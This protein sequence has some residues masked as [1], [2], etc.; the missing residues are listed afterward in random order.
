MEDLNHYKCNEFKTL[1]KYALI[2]K[3]NSR[4]FFAYLI[5]L[6]NKSSSCY[7][8]TAAGFSTISPSPGTHFGNN[9]SIYI[10][11]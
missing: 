8:V 11:C 3:T 2:K 7:L 6:Y 1:K 4:Y 5:K 10:F 9:K